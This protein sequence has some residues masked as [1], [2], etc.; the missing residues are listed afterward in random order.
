M[1]ITKRIK[2]ITRNP[3]NSFQ[4]V[5]TFFQ[6]DEFNDQKAL[7][8]L[9]S[10]TSYMNNKYPA[11]SPSSISGERLLAEWAENIAKI[12]KIDLPLFKIIYQRP[13]PTPLIKWGDIF[14]NNNF[15]L[16]L[17]TTTDFQLSLPYWE[18]EKNRI[19]FLLKNPSMRLSDNYPDVDFL[20]SPCDKM[21]RDLNKIFLPNDDLRPYFVRCTFCYFYYV[22]EK[23][24]SFKCTSPKC[25]RQ[26]SKQRSASWRQENPES[27]LKR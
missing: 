8:K 9:L 13:N 24:N 15:S 23:S 16:D 14:T 12:K 17:R 10:K 20:I 5:M 11:F 26:Y 4:R 7:I 1:T 25:T 6:N 18:I 2:E 27:K 3:S 21:I 22:S 19:L